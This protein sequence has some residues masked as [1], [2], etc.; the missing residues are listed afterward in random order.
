MR[1]LVIDGNCSITD[2]GWL[3]FE[4]MYRGELFSFLKGKYFLVFKLMD[5]SKIS[6]SIRSVSI[7]IDSP[8]SLN[9]L[10]MSFLNLPSFGPLALGAVASP[11]YLYNPTL[12]ESKRGLILF[13]RYNPTSSHTSAPSKLPIVTSN[14][15]LSSLLT[16]APLLSNNKDF[17]AWYLMLIILCRLKIS[18]S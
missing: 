2:G 4:C 17:L 15:G 3:D 5:T 11:S 16:Q 1:L 10:I 9:K 18:Q 14:N 7:L 6:D 13:R 12:L 8:P